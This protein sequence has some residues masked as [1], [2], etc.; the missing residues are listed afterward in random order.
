MKIVCDTNVLVSGLVW[1][2]TPGA[3]W[4]RVVAGKDRLCI[5][6][7]M[8]TEVARVLDYP[9]IAKVLRKRE[10]ASRDILAAIVGTSD[11][12]WPQPLRACVIRADRDDDAVLACAAAAGASH[13]VTGDQHL[14]ALGSWNAVRI[15]TP[16][17]YLAS[18]GTSRQGP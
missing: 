9:R 11:V 18:R 1:G 7:A 3:V 10:L 4:D 15:L 8:L 5:S 13:I 16:A 6:R 12:I 14:L 2:G 17:D